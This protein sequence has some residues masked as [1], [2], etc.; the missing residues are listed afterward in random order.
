MVS[1][2]QGGKGPLDETNTET[3]VS[4]T[5][6]A[7]HVYQSNSHFKKSSSRYIVVPSLSL[8]VVGAACRFLADI[9]LQTQP[10]LPST[11]DRYAAILFLMLAQG[12]T[13]TWAAVLGKSTQC[14]R[15]PDEGFIASTITTDDSQ[16]NLQ[17]NGDTISHL[18]CADVPDIAVTASFEGIRTNT[19]SGYSS[20][21]LHGLP[22]PR[23]PRSSNRSQTPQSG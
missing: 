16:A 9:V 21:W 13:L 23:R 2:F 14:E 12:Y 7:N 6:T 3:K 20:Q 10:G 19:C 18:N 11:A 1:S 15:N 8:M 17:E 22:H 5:H 4:T